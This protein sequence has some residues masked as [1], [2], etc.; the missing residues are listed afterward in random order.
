MVLTYGWLTLI[1]TP[2]TQWWLRQVLLLRPQELGASFFPVRCVPQASKPHAH[3]GGWFVA[4]APTGRRYDWCP[5][6]ALLWWCDSAIGR[7]STNG[8]LD[9]SLSKHWSAP[10]PARSTDR[11]T[12][13]LHFYYIRPL[14]VSVFSC[15]LV[16]SLHFACFILITLCKRF[17]RTCLQS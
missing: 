15:S 7:L 8:E 1:K 13:G 12:D 5:A 2:N 17:S 16:I 14:V 3:I 11:Q 4:N 10:D 9:L 6:A